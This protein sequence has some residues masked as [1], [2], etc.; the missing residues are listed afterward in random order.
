MKTAKLKTVIVDDEPLARKRISQLLSQEPDVEIVAECAN[1]LA[2]IS[3]INELQPDL[4]FLDVQM[5]EV[6]GFD[7]LREIN[8]E[9]M[10]AIIFITAYDRYTIQAFD[11]SAIDYLLKPF[12]EERFR[13]SVNRVRRHLHP[14]NEN[15]YL[16]SVVQ[17]IDR[18]NSKKKT[19]RRLMINHNNRLI[20][21]PVGNIACVNSYGNYLKIHTSGKTYLIRET[22]N[23]LEARLDPEKFVRIH[24]STLVNIDSIKEIQ[25][26]FGGQYTVLLKDGTELTLSRSYRKN[27]LGKFEG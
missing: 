1:G 15:H 12:S 17:L 27:F 23:N 4:I 24:R 14:H 6:S 3:A 26:L 13:Q 21:L 2:A 5:P 11:F 22:M 7:V 9:N 25:P 8:R 10:P 18:L 16:K 20:L 19:L